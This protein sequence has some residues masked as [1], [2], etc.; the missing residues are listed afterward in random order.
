MPEYVVMA[1]V[2]SLLICDRSFFHYY[3]FFLKTNDTVS[4]KKFVR[5]YQLETAMAT[6]DY[7]VN[8][9][10]MLSPDYAARRASPPDVHDLS[11]VNGTMGESTIIVLY[12]ID[13]IFD[14]VQNEQET[15]YILLNSFDCGT[16]SDAY[17]LPCLIL[18]VSSCMML[19]SFIELQIYVTYYLQ[20]FANDTVTEDRLRELCGV[21]PTAVEG[22][23][24]SLSIRRPKLHLSGLCQ[25][26]VR[27]HGDNDHSENAN[28][29]QGSEC[30]NS[31]GKLKTSGIKTFNLLLLSVLLFSFLKVSDAQPSFFHQD[32]KYVDLFAESDLLFSNDMMRK[33]GCS[34]HYSTST[35][36]DT[37]QPVLPKLESVNFCDS[38]NVYLNLQICEPKKLL[39]QH[40]SGSLEFREHDSSSKQQ[41]V[42]MCITSLWSCGAWFLMAVVS[43]IFE[44]G[45]TTGEY[46]FTYSGLWIMNIFYR[47]ITLCTRV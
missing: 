36:L 7:N 4:T 10:F 32:N 26:D 34:Y 9:K 31:W 13:L 40:E 23:F 30:K 44:G 33:A 5:P 46:F 18:I 15:V 39:I 42:Y 17:G 37:P 47:S 21:R 1:L 14:T 25:E 16:E 38:G 11:V 22:M 45:K 28:S 19:V 43:F 3:L 20:F 6:S 12:F 8:N 27:Q 2:I 35:Q 24:H 29:H 41:Y